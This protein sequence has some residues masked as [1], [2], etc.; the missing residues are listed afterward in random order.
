V[1][2][3]SRAQIPQNPGYRIFRNRRSH[4]IN[5]LKN[6]FTIVE[7]TEIYSPKDV[8]ATDEPAIVPIRS[9]DATNRADFIDD[10]I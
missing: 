4:S 7:S 5:R 3:H 10:G 6:G 2:C 1:E 8:I 9:C